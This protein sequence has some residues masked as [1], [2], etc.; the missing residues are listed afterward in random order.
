[1]ATVTAT[2]L[3][4]VVVLSVSCSEVVIPTITL[5][6]SELD[7]KHAVPMIT[8]ERAAELATTWAKQ[9][10]PFNRTLIET[11]FQRRVDFARLTAGSVS[12]AESPYRD[13]SPE[14]PMPEKKAI[15]P[16]YIVTLEQDG[17]PAVAVSVSAFST[18]LTIKNGVIV[19]P[20]YS[21]H[22][23]GWIGIR[24]GHHFPYPENAAV[25]AVQS[26]SGV[27][28]A[29]PA[30][31]V[32]PALGTW[33]PLYARWRIPL[34]AHVL[35]RTQQGPS[36]ELLTDVV[37]VDQRGHL[38]VQTDNVEAPG[39]RDDPSDSGPAVRNGMALN[40]VRVSEIRRGGNYE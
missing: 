15:G 24:S 3:P 9:F 6:K 22:D 26:R 5:G 36:A 27:R 33:S 29:G 10:G 38:Y 31:L 13:L 37:Y 23:F 39:L 20:L 11:G 34:T 19:F 35:V 2:Y 28:V 18:D 21:G 30:T 14:L 7:L 1:M 40:F 8:S 25:E 4:L 16:Y 17:V 12:L 32:R